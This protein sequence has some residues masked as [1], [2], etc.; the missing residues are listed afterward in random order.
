MVKSRKYQQADFGLSTTYNDKPAVALAL[1]AQLHLNAKTK[2][3]QP[4][5]IPTCP[6]PISQ[7]KLDVLSKKENQY[8][9]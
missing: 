2:T 7:L 6:V 9:I 3:T 1:Q 8:K 4:A 5:W